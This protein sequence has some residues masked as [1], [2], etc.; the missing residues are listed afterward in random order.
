[1]DDNDTDAQQRLRRF[2][3]VPRHQS[4]LFEYDNPMTTTT[5]E[6]ATTGDSDDRLNIDSEEF[7]TFDQF[8]SQDDAL[9][10]AAEHNDELTED[11][12]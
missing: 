1:M 5:D 9:D 12:R 10:A 2:G 7:W 4:T 3:V 6:T 11:D 8:D